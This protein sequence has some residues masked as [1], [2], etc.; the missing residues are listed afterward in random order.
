MVCRWGMNPEI[1]TVSY[2]KSEGGFLGEQESHS[3]FSEETART[4][5]REVKK[6]IDGCYG[7][8]KKIL[9]QE[10]DYLTN[11][12]DMLLVNETL[13][14]EEMDIVYNCSITKRGEVQQGDEEADSAV[15]SSEISS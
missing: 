6:I 8:A 12:A 14:R 13:D 5:D 10:Q 9:E 1:G 11:L 3:A 4:I 2:V 7:E 15:C